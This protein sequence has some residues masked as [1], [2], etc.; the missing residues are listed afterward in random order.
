MIVMFF[1]N[2]IKGLLI[3]AISLLSSITLPTQMISALS[4]I[5]GYGAYV[6]GGDLLLIVSS[7][8]GFWLTAKLTVGLILFVWRLMPFT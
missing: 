2:L 8:I 5:T 7:A 3:G 1:V 6:V 4:T